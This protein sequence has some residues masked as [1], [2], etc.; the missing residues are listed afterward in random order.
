MEN[1]RLWQEFWTVYG[2]NWGTGKRPRKTKYASLASAKERVRD[3]KQRG[4]DAR[5]E[6]HKVWLVENERA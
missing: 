1:E 4:F 3:L 5:I 6:H 2:L